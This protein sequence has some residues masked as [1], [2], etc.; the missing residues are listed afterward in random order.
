MTSQSNEEAGKGTASTRAQEIA[1]KN[2]AKYPPAA[3]PSPAVT[4]QDIFDLAQSNDML[5][6]AINNPAMYW[7]DRLFQRTFLRHAEQVAKD[8]GAHRD[9]VALELLRR[10]VSVLR[11]SVRGWSAGRELHLALC[12]ILCAISGGGKSTA[13]S[14]AAKAA[15]FPELSGDEC[16]PTLRHVQPDQ[17]LKVEERGLGSGEGILS[18]FVRSRPPTAQERE[19]ADRDDMTLPDRVLVRR[20]TRVHV[21]DPEGSS[22]LQLRERRGSILEQVLLKAPFGEQLDTANSEE[23]GRDR[24]VEAGTYRLTTGFGGQPIVLDALYS[25]HSKG[26]PQRQVLVLATPPVD[27]TLR[28]DDLDAE[29]DR[30][31]SGDGDVGTMPPRLPGIQAEQRTYFA[32][33]LRDLEQLQD[34]TVRACPRAEKAIHVMQQRAALQL[35]D[36]VDHHRPAIT[37]ALACTLAL[38]DGRKEMSDEDWALACSIWGAHTHVRKY[39]LDL[40]GIMRRIQEAEENEARA[41]SRAMS[42]RAAEAARDERKVVIQTAT[43]ILNQLDKSR[44]KPVTKTALVKAGVISQRR[45]KDWEDQ[46]GE[47]PR[48]LI[49]AALDYLEGTREV[50]LVDVGRTM[51]YTR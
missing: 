48:S 24:V 19:D 1:A 16:P 25:D 35:V 21:C 18:R 36:P 47:D 40:A 34:V 31:N 13:F 10:A 28:A 23:N 30:L 14:S 38:V 20:A 9:A 4:D 6:Q 29:L 37:M 7:P 11:I 15:P 39:M 45:K 5:R 22:L 17:D 43:S 12:I 32:Q 46:R 8:T 41:R 26:F 27:E 44:G 3:L 49:D 2:R 51:A 42:E 50:R 33:T